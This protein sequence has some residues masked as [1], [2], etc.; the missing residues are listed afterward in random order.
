MDCVDCLTVC[1][2]VPA[3]RPACLPAWRC[4]HTTCPCPVCQPQWRLPFV[5]HPA[6]SCLRLGFSLSL[7]IRPVTWEHSFW[8]SCACQLAAKSVLFSTTLS[9]CPPLPLPLLYQ[10]VDGAAIAAVVRVVVVVFYGHVIAAKEIRCT[11]SA[12]APA[13][14]AWPLSRPN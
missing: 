8:L 7:C 13:R 11:C 4:C 3:C 6:L 2:A 10:P 1:V 5:L 9:H 12:P 14:L